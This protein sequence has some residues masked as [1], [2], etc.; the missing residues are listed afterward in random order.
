MP[1]NHTVDPRKRYEAAEGYIR[2]PMKL[3]LRMP[4]VQPVINSVHVQ[5]EAKIRT[6]AKV[7]SSLLKIPPTHK[8]NTVK[9]I[10]TAKLDSSESSSSPYSARID[11]EASISGEGLPLVTSTFENEPMDSSGRSGL[12]GIFIK[13]SNLPTMQTVSRLASHS[14]PAVHQPQLHA[15]YTDIFRIENEPRKRHR[16]LPRMRRASLLQIVGVIVFLASGSVALQSYRLNAQAKKQVEVLAEY[17]N[18]DEDALNGSGNEPSEVPVVQ[19]VVSSYKPKHPEY[20]R[21]LRIP[22]IGVI[23]RVKDLGLTSSGAVDAPW[24]VR[25]TGWYSG[26]K[27]YDL[28]W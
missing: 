16:R 10:S 14:S 7:R 1:D 27:A 4:A 18:L 11:S 21:Y 26:A 8:L 6:Q 12:A 28:C 5:P 25:D 20:P 17:V 22:E 23:S 9:P 2:R 15:T 19:K 3:D 13:S 24:N